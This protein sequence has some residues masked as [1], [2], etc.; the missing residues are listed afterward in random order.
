MYRPGHYG[1]VLLLYSVVGHAL[2]SRRH[3]SHALAGTAL[4]LLVTMTPDWDMYVSWLPHRGPTHSVGF[5]LVVGAVCGLL[6]VLGSRYLG[7][8]SR[9]SA[10][11]GIW[12]TGLGTFS[13]LTHVLADAINP[14][15][16]RPFYPFSDMHVTLNL[17]PAS[18]PVWNTGLLAVGLLVTAAC[19][20]VASDRTFHEVPTLSVLVRRVYRYLR[21]PVPE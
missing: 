4:V 15:G 2:L 19:W 9:T 17:V 10:R 12:A 8:R 18:D 11:L 21:D 6:V 1:M 14:V 20:Q 16:V 13:V 3:D 5:A 7:Q